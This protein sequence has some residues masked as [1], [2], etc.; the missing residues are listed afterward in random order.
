MHLRLDVLDAS[1]FS[2]HHTLTVNYI[3]LL[4]C[5]SLL[6]WCDTDVICPSFGAEALCSYILFL[7]TLDVSPTQCIWHLVQVVRHIILFSSHVIR[8]GKSTVLCD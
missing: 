7:N 8:F 6:K 5:P 2:M 3:S 4:L 1:I